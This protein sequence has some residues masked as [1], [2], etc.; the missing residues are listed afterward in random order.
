MHV[1]QRRFPLKGIPFSR[2]A[3]FDGGSVAL[4][5]EKPIRI[6]IAEN[7]A[8]TR[9]SFASIID[10]EPG[11]ELVGTAADGALAEQT[12]HLGASDI[13]LLDHETSGLD[14][15]AVVRQILRDRPEAQV[16]V[17]A[18]LGGD[19]HLFDFICAGAQ[20]YL[21]HDADE[22]EILD[23][24]RAV[25]RGQSR[26]APALTRKLIEEFRRICHKAC[27]DGVPYCTPEEPLT[28]RE[29]DI[30]RLIIAGKSNRAIASALNL[31]EGTVKNY[32]SRIMEKSNARSRTEL[33][34]KSLN[35]R[36]E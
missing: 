25:A 29:K 2:H 9:R 30:L 22:G 28:D 13:F 24:I 16:I 14:G 11:F 3:V 32:V 18:G 12:V 7:Q 20:A 15:A 31:A 21:P 33:A 17:R 5:P 23:T 10:G 35:R 19:G 4:P 8:P 27:G 36:G 1:S 34:V 6:F 26:L